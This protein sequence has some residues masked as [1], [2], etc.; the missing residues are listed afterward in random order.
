MAEAEKPRVLIL[1]GVGFIG[2]HLVKH[3]VDNK[4]ASKVCVVDKVPP[5][6][7]WMNEQHK[8]T[9]QQVEF[10]SA[11]LSKEVGA[12]KAFRQ[13]AG[14]PA[15]DVVFNLAAET[16]YGLTEEVYQEKVTNIVKHCT[17]QAIRQGAKKWIEVSSAQVYS[18][19]KDASKEGNK[20]NPWT[21]QAKAKRHAEVALQKHEKDL[22]FVIVRPVTVYGVGDKS[23]LTPRLVI[24][25]V[26]KYLREPMKLL[27][28]KDLCMNTV[29]V[30]DVVR[31][32]WHLTTSGVR[33]EVYNL[34]DKGFTTQGKL[35]ELLSSLYGIEHDY[36]GSILSNLAKL[37]MASA[38]DE[39][40]EKHTGPWS[41]AC[42]QDN[43]TATPLTPYINQ[44]L[45]Y[46]KHLHVDGSKIEKTGFKYEVPEV[47]VE[48]L[49]EI[50]EDFVVCG[51][52]PPS[53]AP[54]KA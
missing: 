45:L 26:Y 13:E 40:N 7:G 20:P 36:F 17:L 37:N 33:G 35:A 44:E 6:A 27:W 43:V 22:D 1:G 50:V 28:T 41:E 46:N 21:E 47:K 9:F 52:F 32:L 53:L 11:D 31:G 49:R 30:N 12:E 25:A 2:R 48:L 8:L 39:S 34:A 18:K 38:T 4:L 3:I 5:I 23:G 14:D 16:K 54:P 19:D 29:H 42:K 51:L 15:Y 24:G 10:V